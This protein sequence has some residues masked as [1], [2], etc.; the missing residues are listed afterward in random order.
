MALQYSRPARYNDHPH[1]GPRTSH[2][3]R[4]MSPVA[5]KTTDIITYGLNMST[6]L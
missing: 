4:D 1:A 3:N 2:F 6:T 5:V